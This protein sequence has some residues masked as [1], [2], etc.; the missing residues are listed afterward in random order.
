MGKTFYTLADKVDKERLSNQHYHNTSEV[1]NNF[2]V[3]NKLCLTNGTDADW[4][5]FCNSEILTSYKHENY[6]IL[7]VFLA[8]LTKIPIR[9]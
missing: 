6:N 4:V 3:Y 5:E 1:K 2:T 8:S 7:T 9:P